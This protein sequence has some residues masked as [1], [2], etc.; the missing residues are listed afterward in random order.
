MN[1]EVINTSDLMLL[2]A[3]LLLIFLL[4]HHY[5]PSEVRKRFAQKEQKSLELM[6]KLE[7]ERQSNERWTRYK[8]QSELALCLA[9]LYEKKRYID[10]EQILL[11]EEYLVLERVDNPNTEMKDMPKIIRNHLLA[12]ALA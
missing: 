2:I 8:R 5:R 7:H 4:F 12:R 10:D 9:R 11:M 6:R 1:T 3:I